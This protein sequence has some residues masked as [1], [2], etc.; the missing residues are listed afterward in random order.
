MQKDE[1]EYK[2][3]NFFSKIKNKIK[4]KT[5]NGDFIEI[6]FVASTEDGTVFDTNMEEEAR[7]IGVKEGDFKPF[8]L[9]I[10]QGMIVK[11]MD[12]A[13]EDKETDKEYIIELVPEEA[14]GKR[15]PRLI[16]TVPLSAFNEMPRQ[17]MFININSIVAK[18]VSVTGGRVLVDLN[19]PLAG[20]KVSYKFKINKIIVDNDEKIKIV[21]EKFDLEVKK[22]DHTKQPIEIEIKDKKNEKA[23]KELEKKVKELIGLEVKIL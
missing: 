7:K 19:N 9:C 4:M 5:K 23:S 20:K 18:V 8:R 13:L 10:G 21:A 1:K 22:I 14:F 12:K 17:G 11:G 2:P 3:N 6:E 16:K 15:D